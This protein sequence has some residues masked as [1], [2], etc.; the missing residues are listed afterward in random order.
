M[1][2]L[3][4]RADLVHEVGVMFLVFIPVPY[5]DASSSAAFASKWQRAVVGGAGIMVEFHFEGQRIWGA[6]AM[7]LVRFRQYILKQ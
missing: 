5:V 6:T 4:Q 2:L 3:S 1:D 7:M